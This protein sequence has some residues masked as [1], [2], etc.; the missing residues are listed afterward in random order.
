QSQFGRSYSYG[1]WQPN[2]P[3]KRPMNRLGIRAGC[4]LTFAV[5]V[6]TC[7][8]LPIRA[9]EGD[10]SFNRFSRVFGGSERMAG[11]RNAQPAPRSGQAGSPDV[12]LRLE[13]LESQIRQLTGVIEQL[14]YRN[15][16]L[17]AEVRRLEEG[18]PPRPGAQT[19][20]VPGQA[21]PSA[22]GTGVR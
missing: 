19:R 11:E 6:A 4:A 13:R 14:Q 2:R 5:I 21:V 17:E 22:G 10:N 18:G 12:V 9:Q 7:T 15:Q 20:A 1:T 16:Q 3:S 8:A